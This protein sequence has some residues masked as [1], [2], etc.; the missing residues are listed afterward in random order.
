MEL[1]SYM[2]EYLSRDF[3]YPI[4]FEPISGME[5]GESLIKRRKHHFTVDNWVQGFHGM[6]GL[7]GLAMGHVVFSRFD[8]M[9]KEKWE[10]YSDEMIP[11]IDV[12][13]FDTCAM[14]LR[15]FMNDRDLLKQKCIE[16]VE[17]MKKYYTHRIIL[18]KWIDFYERIAK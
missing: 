7:E 1:I 9:A 3:G 11:I 12:K 10:K 13:G 8:P 2:I 4:S 6:A 16:S 15:K 14:H 18:N 5:I 17:W